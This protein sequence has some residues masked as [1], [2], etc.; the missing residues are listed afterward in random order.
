MYRILVQSTHINTTSTVPK[1]LLRVVNIFFINLTNHFPPNFNRTSE[2][3]DQTPHCVVSD[4]SLLYFP[5]S[6][7]KNAK[8][9]WYITD[10]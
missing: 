9:N 6:L 2:D 8:L 4:L 1:L 5:M 10:I 7:K 3:F